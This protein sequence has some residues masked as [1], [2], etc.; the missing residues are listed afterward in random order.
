MNTLLPRR[1]VVILSAALVATGIVRNAAV[2][3]FAPLRPDLAARFWAGHP[4]VQLSE[5]MV[6]IGTAAR[7]RA[8]VGEAA[9]GPINEAAVKSPLAAEPF[10]VRGVRSITAGNKEA[11][12]SAFVMAQIRD[13]RSVP[14]AYFLADYYFRT[15]NVFDGLR[16]MALL[17]RLVP[18]AAA[19]VAPY[20]AAYAH[21]RSTW[22]QIRTVFRT[23]SN[24]QQAVLVALAQDAGN[25]DAILGLSD[26]DHRRPDSSWLPMLLNNLV[27]AKDYAKAH[28]VWSAVVGGPTSGDLLYDAGFSARQA[29]PPF[30][31]SLVTATVGLAE[32][33]PGGR[34][35][36][37]FYGN[38]DGVLASQLLLLRPG[39]YRLQM[40][41]VGP[42][43]NAQLLAWSVR[44][45]SS[46][47]P[48]ARMPLGAGTRSVKFEV[49]ANCPAQWIELSGR[50]GEVAEQSD[51][52]IRG[53]SLTRM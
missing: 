13:P 1:L 49:V 31:W 11:A 50:S 47:E 28:A 24:L 38:E 53:L 44:C 34:L 17:T 9:F 32:R 12:R 7:V 25:A 35:H 36:V 19:R 39:N 51:V 42:L 15:G 3:A 37:L 20:V 45:V 6:E 30:N 18:E 5:G 8:K 2:V 21:D 27:K 29:P 4:D 22:P 33:Q 46:L 16:Q 41:V 23:E 10:L 40:A 43:T 14:A 26:A 48:L 52:T